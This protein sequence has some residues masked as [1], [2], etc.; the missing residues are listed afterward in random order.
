MYK[1]NGGSLLI[2]PN[3]LN[4]IFISVKL[5]CIYFFVILIHDKLKKKSFDNLIFKNTVELPS[6]TYQT[7]I[8]KIL[9][10]FT[11]QN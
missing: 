6:N 4:I 7:F 9:T 2:T 3:T 8:N 5:L 11:S 1:Q 10:L